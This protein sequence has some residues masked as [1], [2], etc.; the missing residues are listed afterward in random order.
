VCQVGNKSAEDRIRA[1]RHVEKGHYFTLLCPDVSTIAFYG[2]ASNTAFRLVK[3]LAPGPY[4]FILPATRETPR[5]LQDPKRKMVGLRAP[6]HPF[7]H[8]LLTQLGEP[9]LSATLINDAVALPYAEPDEMAAA[10]GHAVDAIVDCGAI[11]IEMTTVLDLT[12]ERP[13][14]VRAGKGEVGHIS[15]L[16]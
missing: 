2:K 12:G 9:L 8:A 6:A 5:R 4:T 14:V 3:M 15:D 7:V 16:V 1:I 11:G 10:V 13:L